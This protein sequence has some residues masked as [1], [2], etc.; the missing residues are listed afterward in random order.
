[1]R[2]FHVVVAML[3]FCAGTASAQPLFTD[4][5]P[6]EE[7][8]ERRAKLFEKIGDG[9]AIIQGTTETGNALKFRQNNQ[10]YYLTGVEVPRAILLM[11]GRTK[12]S[13]LFLPP[14]NERRERSEGP[15]L[16]TGPEAV[17][18]TGVEAVDV[19]D[20]FDAA[21]KGA[22]TA[23][24]SAYVPFRPEVLGGASVSD[25][26]A[27]WAASAA[28]PW[29]GGRSRETLFLEKVRAAAPALEIKDLD[30][31][32]DALRFIKSPRE[33][34]LIRESTRI[35]GL[36]IMEAMRSARPGMF[37]YEIEAIGDYIFKAHNAQGAAY[38]AL[39]AAG[40]NSH[41]PH[42]HAAQ[43]QTKDGALVLFDY[44][45]DYKYYASDVTREFPING[46]FSADQ[47]ELYGIYLKM[48]KALMTSIKPNVPVREIIKDAVGKMDAAIAAHTFANPKYKEAAGRFVDN[49][50]R[51]LTPAPADPA[52]P[53]RSGSLGHT[54]GMEVHDVNTPHGDVLVPGMVFTIEPALTIPEDRIYVRLE[55]VIL[56][57]ETGYENLSDFVPMEID[58]VERLMREP[59]MFEKY[60]PRTTSP[61]TVQ[62]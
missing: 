9:V 35:A 48:Y 52:A 42:Y 3:F 20:A 61:R 60:S 38:F 55:D 17:Q 15:L 14:R 6:K 16:T 59:G 49:Y 57:T 27:R 31:L 13:T 40:K 8:A 4:S 62:R 1:M 51:R 53:A 26:R 23:P 33:I 41:Y 18:L 36:A 28:D 21:L 29:D 25:P 47:R 50:R 39:V 10:F 58:A 5:L 32:I 22:A 19:R 46:K 37:E 11:D 56:M 54:V 30:P 44:A 12:R 43:T 45:P 2:R 34:A 7:F 24:R